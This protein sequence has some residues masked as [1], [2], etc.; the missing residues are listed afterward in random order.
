M[1][2]QRANGRFIFAATIVRMIDQDQPH[3]RLPLVCSMLRGDVEQVWGDVGHLYASIIDSVE[4][5]TRETAL[6]YISLLANLAE[7]LSLSDLRLLFGLDVYPLLVPFSALVYVPPPDSRDA[8]QLYHSTLRDFLERR[9]LKQNEDS[10]V[11]ANRIHH[12]LAIRCFRTMARMLKRDICELQDPSLLHDEIPD[13]P[14]RRDAVPRALRYACLY[15]F[16]HMERLL[17][18]GEIQGCLLE[19]LEGRLLFAVEACTVL[20]ELDSVIRLF[21]AARKH[22]MGWPASSFPGMEQTTGLLYDAWRLVVDFYDPINASALHIYESALPCAPEKSRIRLTYSRVLAEAT[23]FTFEEGL[24]V[25]WGCVTRVIE[26]K[27]DQFELSLSPDT[28][29]VAAFRRDTERTG[30]IMLWDTATGALITSYLLEDMTDAVEV[31]DVSKRK[32]EVTH[33]GSFVAFRD[34][35]QCYLWWP[36]SQKVVKIAAPQAE[37]FFGPLAISRNSDKIASVSVSARASASDMSKSCTVRIHDTASL[38]PISS[39]T[40]PPR[41]KEFPIIGLDFSSKDESLLVQ[42]EMVTQTGDCL[43][44][45]I[46]VIDSIDGQLLWHEQFNNYCNAIFSPDDDIILCFDITNVI[47]LRRVVSPQNVRAVRP[48]SLFNFSLSTFLKDRRSSQQFLRSYEKLPAVACAKARTYK[49]VDLEA[50]PHD[51]PEYVADPLPDKPVAIRQGGKICALTY[52]GGNMKKTRWRMQNDECFG[53]ADIVGYI[54]APIV[55]LSLTATVPPIKSPKLEMCK[56]LQLEIEGYTRLLVSKRGDVAVYGSKAAR[57]NKYILV[58]LDLQSVRDT[59]RCNIVPDIPKVVHS[60]SVDISSREQFVFS[61]KSTY[62]AVLNIRGGRGHVQVWNSRS[63][64]LIGSAPVSPPFF[65]RTAGWNAIF[66]EDETLLA[67]S[68]HVHFTSSFIGVYS[69]E[70]NTVKHLGSISPSLFC[71]ARY[72]LASVTHD[73][74]NYFYYGDNSNLFHHLQWRKATSTSVSVSSIPNL[75]NIIHIEHSASFQRIYCRRYME[76]TES[77]LNLKRPASE[78]T[79]MYELEEDDASKA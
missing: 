38:Q 18:D 1:L 60:P 46:H 49:P 31:V 61:P 74:V 79:G 77:A 42:A 41:F 50:Y 17:P 6:R 10:R 53:I 63:G 22:I 75:G 57:G 36:S 7:P 64:V 62:F 76:S 56:A 52:G 45:L 43:F 26:M 12:P 65:V 55:D 73:A 23:S 14:Q 68:D 28:S 32:V 35:R 78:G 19:F 48:S 20:G 3:E 16:H 4:P 11:S 58:G 37:V 9:N 13:F 44:S 34:S 71:R 25:Q 47:L 40:F 69:L 70:G 66:S 54:T 39:W 8:V 29:Q 30:T 15:W 2:A 24:D 51:R 59:F 72:L 67:L 33:G 5:S 27:T 21:R